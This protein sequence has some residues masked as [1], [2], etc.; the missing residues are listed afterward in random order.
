[1]ALSNRVLCKK[2]YG[3]FFTFNKKSTIFGE[4]LLKKILLWKVENQEN[5]LLFLGFFAPI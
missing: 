1:M 5:T 2:Y 4:L 3:L